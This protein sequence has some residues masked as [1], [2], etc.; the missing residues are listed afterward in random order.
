MGLLLAS[1]AVLATLALDSSWLSVDISQQMTFPLLHVIAML[2][3]WSSLIGFFLCIVGTGRVRFVGIVTCLLTGLWWFTLAMGSAIS[4]GALPIARHPTEYLIPDGY[5]GWVKIKRGEDAPPLQLMNEKYIC[6]IPQTGRLATS[7]LIEEG[8]ARD[9]YSY[10]NDQGPTKTLRN[11]S[12]GGGGMIWDGKTEFEAT[13][14]NS[15]PRRMTEKFFVGSEDQYRHS[16]DQDAGSK[17]P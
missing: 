12:W 13:N 1:F 9:Q 7:S 4:M 3:F 8:W 2:I 10:Y 16:T 6:R 14:G 15:R 5:I 17:Y 11:T